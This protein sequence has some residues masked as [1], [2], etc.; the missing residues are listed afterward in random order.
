MDDE[1]SLR[2]Q[3]ESHQSSKRLN[4]AITERIIQITTHGN[5]LK[6]ISIM[7]DVSL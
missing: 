5:T 4:E 7:F 1:K 2:Y 3:V 6:Y